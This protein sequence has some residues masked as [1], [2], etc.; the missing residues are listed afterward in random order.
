MPSKDQVYGNQFDKSA[1]MKDVDLEC[2]IQDTR[3]ECEPINPT[4]KTLGNE[5]SHETE[6][7]YP[8]AAITFVEAVE[9]GRAKEQQWGLKDIC[10]TVAVWL[11][12]I[13]IFTA[14]L[15]SAR[16]AISLILCLFMVF[17]SLALGGWPM[18]AAALK[19]NGPRI[20]FGLTLQLRD[21]GWGLVY[22]ILSIFVLYAATCLYY[23]LFFSPIYVY[24]YSFF[25]YARGYDGYFMLIYWMTFDVFAKEMFCCGIVLTTLAKSMK[26]VQFSCVWVVLITAAVFSVV[27]LSYPGFFIWFFL[28]LVFATARY[29]T[30]SLT[31]V[32]LTH[33]L[34]YLLYILLV[35]II[36]LSISEEERKERAIWGINFATVLDVGGLQELSFI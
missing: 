18:I 28:G 10:I 3:A 8:G 1:E 35:I 2:G 14:I 12:V 15:F 16:G 20:D 25:G 6:S 22:G 24:P 4:E 34:M 23:L 19:G 5:Q 26:D 36:F 11:L 9:E 32:I 13:A 7:V 29:H 31:V 30:G 27:N 21:F 17:T 33:S